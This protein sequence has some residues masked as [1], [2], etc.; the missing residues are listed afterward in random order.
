[1]RY[2]RAANIKLK[3]PAKN[4]NRG[5]V[6]YKAIDLISPKEIKRKIHLRGHEINM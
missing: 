2:S 3:D 1:M 5:N 4:S 6:E